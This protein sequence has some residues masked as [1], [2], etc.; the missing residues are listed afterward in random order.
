MTIAAGFG[1]Q[2]GV[3]I[4]A[5]RQFSGAS[6]KL[7]QTKLSHL[8]YIDIDSLDAPTL[9][10]IFAMSGTD[11]Y[12]QMAV[13]RCEDALVKLASDSSAN[14]DALSVRDA[15]TDALVEVHNKHFFNH[16]RYG[17]TDGP[18]VS[19]V[20]GVRPTGEDALLYWTNE[21]TINQVVGYKCVGSGAEIAS[22][23]M[24]PLYENS[25]ITLKDLLLV[26]TH[27]LRIAKQYD[28]YCGGESE[29][30]IL[31]DSGQKSAVEGFEISAAEAYST[32]FQKIMRDLFFASADLDKEDADVRRVVGY[33]RSSAD[34]IRKEQRKEQKKRHDLLTRLARRRRVQ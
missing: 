17:Y 31:L 19:L 20:I 7:F 14:V 21:T 5:D 22:Y 23:A 9:K 16:P 29:F 25:S 24:S 6:V 27:G 28:P 10:S 1:F 15:L 4:C 26:A 11:G 13:E 30:A 8:D 3:M 18:S 12:M 34:Q 32:T 2:G 33:L